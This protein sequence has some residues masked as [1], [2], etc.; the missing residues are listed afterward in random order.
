MALHYARLAEQ[1]GAEPALPLPDPQLS[2]DAA[3]MH[4]HVASAS[5][6]RGR[7]AVF[8]PGAEYGPAKRWPHFAR[9]GRA[10]LDVPV[11]LLG[12]AKRARASAAAITGTQPVGKTTLDEAIDLI[13]GAR[14]W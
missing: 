10:Q 9:A 4:A 13:A 11:V 7:Y 8:C 2:V 12:S 14:R 3:A 6:S 1:P 5:A